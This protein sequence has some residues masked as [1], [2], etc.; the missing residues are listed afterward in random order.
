MG[1]DSHTSTIVSPDTGLA[2]DMKTTVVEDA[3]NDCGGEG[4]ISYS[5]I[6]DFRQF[7]TEKNRRE[8]ALDQAYEAFP[9]M[10]HSYGDEYNFEPDRTGRRFCDRCQGTGEHKGDGGLIRFS[11]DCTGSLR[12]LPQDMFEH[13]MR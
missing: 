3:C 9:D 8:A 4:Y 5:T 7:I 2:Y 11:I 10:D 12:S 1:S 13:G 6:A